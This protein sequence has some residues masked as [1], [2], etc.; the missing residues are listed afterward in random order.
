MGHVPIVAPLL[1]NVD[2]KTRIEHSTEKTE[3]AR[4]VADAQERNRRN[5]A[6]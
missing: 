1:P 2:T 4:R 5:S 6:R 3:D